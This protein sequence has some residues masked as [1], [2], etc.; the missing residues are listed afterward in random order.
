M[1]V[2]FKRTRLIYKKILRHPKV[3]Q[4]VTKESQTKPIHHEE[5]QMVKSSVNASEEQSCKKALL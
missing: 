4:E 5:K 2:V 1:T 3:L